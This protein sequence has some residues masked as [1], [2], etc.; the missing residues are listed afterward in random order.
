MGC[1]D[2]WPFGILFA[3]GGDGHYMRRGIL[4]FP[5]DSSLLIEFTAIGQTLHCPRSI[6]PLF[7]HFVQF[8][9]FRFVSFSV[10]NA[11]ELAF[12]IDCNFRMERWRGPLIV[13]GTN[14]IKRTNRAFNLDTIGGAELNLRTACEC[15]RRYPDPY[16]YIHTSPRIFLNQIEIPLLK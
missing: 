8:V 15:I 7:F 11:H 16:I 9:S 13:I 1:G 2:C 12:I 10:R 14:S 3:A 5:Y 4:F 6:A